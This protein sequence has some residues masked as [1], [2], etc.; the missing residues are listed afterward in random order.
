MKKALAFI[1][2]IILALGLCACDNTVTPTQSA[3]PT[4]D[5]QQE[6]TVGQLYITEVISKNNTVL[7]DKDGQYS[8]YIEIY[9]ASGNRI[10]LKGYYLSDNPQKP[11]K[12]E[13]PNVYIEAGQYMVIFASGKDIVQGDQYHA[14][15]S[16]SATEGEPITLVAPDGSVVSRVNMGPC[17]L[18]DVSYG[19]VQQGDAKDT[20]AWFASPTPGEQNSGQYAEKIEDLVFDTVDIIINEYI[21]KNETVI[22]DAD[23]DYSDFIEIYNPGTESVDL[24]G[25]ALSDDLSQ[26][27]KWEFP[28]GTTI[29]AGEYLL[30][31]ASGKDKKTDTELH[32]NF[33]LSETDSGIVLSDNRGHIVDSV[34]MV[35]LSDNVSYG[36][37]DGTWMYFPNPTP[38]KANTNPAF[39]AI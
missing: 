6:L 12:W 20:Y 19:L 10:P 24:S 2:A 25:M 21:T 7:A 27:D 1:S 17:N 26:P 5:H 33:K 35:T 14:S 34:N 30:I 23:G 28:Q 8:D 15:F 13:L 3:A 11:K 37:K 16:I 22:Y 9:N 38:G 29:G 32:T 31:F 39:E 18:A 4:P 36:L